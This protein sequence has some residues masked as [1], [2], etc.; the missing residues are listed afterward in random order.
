MRQGRRLLYEICGTTGALRSREVKIQLLILFWDQTHVPHTQKFEVK[1][2]QGTLL[3]KCF[4][5]L[6]FGQLEVIFIVL[7]DPKLL[8]ISCFRS[9]LV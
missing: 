3:R 4:V 5:T 1:N 9:A 2:L 8:K 6:L 7:R